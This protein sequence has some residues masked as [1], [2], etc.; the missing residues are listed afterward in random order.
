MEVLARNM[1]LLNIILTALS[2]GLPTTLGRV[3]AAT[4]PVLPLVNQGMSM[5]GLNG[6]LGT[7]SDY[8]TLKYNSEG[9]EQWVARYN[10]SENLYDG[11]LSLAIDDSENVYVTGFSY[12]DQYCS[13]YVTIKYIQSTP[14]SVKEEEIKKPGSY[15]L[16]QNYPNPFNPGTVIAYELKG[17]AFV[18]LKVYD[19]MGKEV[20]TLVNEKQTGVSYQVIWNG[21]NKYGKEVSS[22]IY[23]CQLRAGDFYQTK[24]MILIR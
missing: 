24:K 15:L 3:S 22:G 5:S 19:L 21:R 13:E 12:I 10:G 17:T 11:A 14:V 20:I 9:I 2:S 4:Q 6:G 23:F 1:L 16:Y 7:D 8:A 18:N